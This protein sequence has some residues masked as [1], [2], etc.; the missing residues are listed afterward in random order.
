MCFLRGRYALF[1]ASDC[2]AHLA[3]QSFPRSL[4][5]HETPH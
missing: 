5:E 2:A 4:M 1:L 3:C